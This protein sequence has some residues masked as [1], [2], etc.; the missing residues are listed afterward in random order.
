MRL[1]PIYRRRMMHTGLDIAAPRGTSIRAALGGRVTFVG[2]KGGYGKTVV[3]EHPNGYETLYG[4][5]RRFSS[6]VER[7]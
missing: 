1:H 4:H 6:S 5:C 3:I 2:W 7:P